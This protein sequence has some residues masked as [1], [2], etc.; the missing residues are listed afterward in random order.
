MALA[1]N[2]DIYCVYNYYPPDDYNNYVDGEGRCHGDIAVTVSQDG[3]A[4]WF[5]PTYI[6][7]TSSPLADVGEAMCEVYPTVSKVV[8]DYL[9]IFYLLDREAGS[10]VQDDPASNT[11]NPVYYLRV[12]IAEVL[13]DS[14]WHGPAFH[15]PRPN[16]VRDTNPWTPDGFRLTGAYP[17]P[18]NQSTVVEFDVQS[19]Q[20][21]DLALY[22]LD[23]RLIKN[24]YSGE[25][26]SG[27]HRVTLDGRD[28]AAG[29]Y[30]VKLK[31]SQSESVMKVTYLR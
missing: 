15:V 14:I 7:T 10:V 2:G 22:G 24:L 31:G 28:L 23:G 3:G 26:L 17:N 16:Q 20:I 27:H 12:P 6:T 8:E 1:G 19:K 29:L 21:I 4:T 5:Y 11:L 18:F 13:T 30:F 25:V 9:E